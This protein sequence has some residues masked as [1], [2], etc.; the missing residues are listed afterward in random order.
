MWKQK[1][2]I[3]LHL[4]RSKKDK[5]NCLCIKT[6]SH[7]LLQPASV[8]QVTRPHVQTEFY[9]SLKNSSGTVSAL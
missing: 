4:I 9:H 7:Y 5:D 3:C 1:N 2:R 8:I 6:V